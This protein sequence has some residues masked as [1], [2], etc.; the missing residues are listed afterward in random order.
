[1]LCIHR[2]MDFSLSLRCCFDGVTKIVEFSIHFAL[3]CG[4]LPTVK[5]RERYVEDEKLYRDI[6]L[7]FICI[8]STDYPQFHAA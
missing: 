5:G 7:N 4:C 6:S 8:L 2:T 1:M 3:L